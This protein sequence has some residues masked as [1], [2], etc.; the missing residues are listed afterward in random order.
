MKKTLYFLLTACILI[1][2]SSVQAQQVTLEWV[3]NPLDS[4]NIGGGNI[5]GLSNSTDSDGNIYI[6]G[7]FEGIANF[8]PSGTANLTSA[9]SEDIFLVKYDASGNYLWAIRIGGPNTDI[10]TSVAVDA[11]GNIYISGYFSAS[12]N[13]DPNGTANLISSGIEDIFLAKYDASGNYLWAIHMGSCCS[14][15]R[16]YGVA[17]DSLG[18][19]YIT[20]DFHGTVNFNPNGTANL[21]SAGSWDIFLAKYDALGNYLWARRMGGTSR[22]EGRSVAVDAAGNAYI[23]G[24]FQGTANFDSDGSATLTSAGNA[25]IF[26]AKYDA[27]GNYLWAKSMGGTNFDIGY[28]VALDISGNAYLTG[29]F[30]GTANFNT[31]DTFSLTSAGGHDVF[32]AKYDYLGNYLWA[33]S[34]GGTDDDVGWSVKVDASS[35][36]YITGHFQVTANF[37]PDGTSNLSS[38]GNNDIFL[39]KYNASGNY[40]WAKS[41]GGT[42]GD[43]SFS[44]AL[45]INNN[46]YITGRFIGTA[47]FNPDGTANIVG[48]G[49]LSNAFNA[50]YSNEGDFYYAFALGGFGN[51]IFDQEAYAVATDSDGNS[52]ITGLFSGTVDFNPSENI[53]NLTSRGGMDIFLAKYD[54]SGNYLWAKNMGGKSDD[55]GISIAIDSSDNIYILGSFRDTAYFNSDDSIN[56]ISAGGADVFLAKY[57]A[58]GNYLW[59]KSM[60]GINDDIGMSVAIDGSGNAYITGHFE[61]IANFNPNDTANLASV[62]GRDIFLAKYD[63]FG[64]YLWAKRMGGTSHDYCYGVALDYLGNAYITGYFWGTSNFNPDGIANLTSAGGSDVF[65][66][67]YDTSGNYLW[68]KRIG[69]P[70]SDDGNAVVVDALG[71]TYV[72]GSFRATANFNPDGTANLTSTGNLDIFLAKYDSSGNYLWAKKMGSTSHDESK[73]V[74]LDDSGNAYITGYF[75][76]TA[77]FNLDG[78]ANLISAGDKDIFLAKYDALGNYLWAKSMGGT[79]NDISYAVALNKLGN[80]YITGYFSES[81]NFNTDGTTTISS[82]NGNDIFLAK[83]SE[84]FITFA[85]DTITACNSY[86]WIDGST[87]TTNNNTATYTLKNAAGCDSV[88]T[89][90]LT[91]NAPP[92]PNG[93]GVQAFCDSATIADLV[94]SSGSSIKW[95]DSAT[96]GNLLTNTTLLTHA[97]SYYATQTI[98]ECESVSRLQVTVIINSTPSNTVTQTDI[99]L[100]ADAINASYQWLDCDNGNVAI[101]GETKQSFTP[102]AS[103]SYAAEITSD[104]CSNTSNC[105]T[106]IVLSLSNKERKN[107]TVHPNPMEDVIHITSNEA[108]QG[109]VIITTEGKQ[110]LGQRE[111]KSASVTVDVHELPA[112]FYVIEVTNSLG[113]IERFKVT[114]LK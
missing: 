34:M 81:A 7:R 11:L 109:Y 48:G 108:I 59:A 79:S 93:A 15:H 113:A 1:V 37:N 72:T 42:S 87:Y 49:T 25:D 69:G 53:S 62:G 102:I 63:S 75:Q 52:Y 97:T 94:T 2:V 19:A 32:L 64:N 82:I 104:G 76:G 29:L 86:T 21:T 85:T 61:G 38:V 114:K 67:K 44:I 30:Q 3:F 95:Y 12:A 110:V 98:D 31:D 43:V 24:R 18:N 107:I 99:T 10:A 91:I 54:S 71:N 55:A 89:L 5:V 51:I 46:A 27:S 88:I 17:L 22:D 65:L 6:T 105:I 8:N 106:V 20:G 23:T 26:L 35:N 40:L 96:N 28:S 39:A 4:A 58:S 77:N 36:A 41:M 13:F 84:C 112:G 50:K 66:A 111:L 60:G 101:N 83:Y 45:D 9:G 68:A 16:G 70:N 103:G 90:N 14:G 73:S 56:I 74:A 80:A 100:T 92:A 47:N 78:T 33:I 57:D